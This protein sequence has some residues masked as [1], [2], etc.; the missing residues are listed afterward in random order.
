M[1]YFVRFVALVALSSGAVGTVDAEERVHHTFRYL[2]DAGYPQTF[3]TMTFSPDSSQ[4]AVSVAGRVDFIDPNLGRIT[5]QYK[6]TPFSMAYSKSGERIYMISQYRR[7]LLDTLTGSPIKT[8]R[9]VTP[10]YLGFRLAKQS[11]KLEITYLWEGGPVAAIDRIQVGDELVGIGDG[12]NGNMRDVAGRSVK[13]ALELLAGPAG[14]YVQLRILPR[15]KFGKHNVSTHVVRRQP[16]E[17]VDNEL[18]FTELAVPETGENLAWCMSN[19]RH[20]FS[21]AMTGLPVAQLRTI[22]IANVGL[23]AISPDQKK[24]AVVARRNSDRS[25]NAVEV[26]DIATLNRLAFM[27]VPKDSYSDIAFAGDSNRVLVATWDSIEVADTV[28]GRFV[29]RLDLGWKP[30]PAKPEPDYGGTG[31]SV[32]GAA[33]DDIGFG[34]VNRKRAPRKLVSSLAVSSKNIVATADSFGQVKLWGLNSGQLLEQ[35]PMNPEE[36]PEAIAF[37][38]NGQWLAYH[39]DGV[40]SVVDVSDIKPPAHSQT[41]IPKNDEPD[42]PVAPAQPPA[43]VIPGLTIGQAEQTTPAVFEV[44]AKVEVRSRGQWYPAVIIHDDGEGRWRIHYEDA[45]KEWD[46]LVTKQ[47]MRL[48]H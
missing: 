36:E 11:G 17:Y 18:R 2:T 28:E 42:R 29:G 26:F 12:R 20:E 37:S 45:P 22:N 24:F 16:G 10:G 21:N 44:G 25:K 13:E 32:V 5:G 6:A 7:T 31:G 14:T 1:R 43:E 39:I 40:L 23:Y 33:A 8:K 35:L 30:P 4:L 41:G 3:E 46:E 34:K 38:P 27:P 47:R 19:D 9:V 48:S 15:G